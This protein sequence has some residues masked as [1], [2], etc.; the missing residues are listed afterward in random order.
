MAYSLPGY[1]QWLERPYQDM[2]DEAD[3]YFEWCE[4]HDFDPDDPDSENAYHEF[5]SQ[6]WEEPDWYDYDDQEPD[7]WDLE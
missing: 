4:E 2:I 1:D 6:L 7:D 3:R 5:I